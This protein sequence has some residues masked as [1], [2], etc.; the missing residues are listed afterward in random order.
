MR[1]G[2]SERFASLLEYCPALVAHA[3]FPVTD[4]YLFAV[5]FG[6]IPVSQDVPLVPEG[7]WLLASS[8]NIG[9]A[10]VTRA[11]QR[12]ANA[13]CRHSYPVNTIII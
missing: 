12:T 9:F 13:V 7:Y 2:V 6:L 1:L 10:D 4:L 11:L 3:S 5:G 8:R